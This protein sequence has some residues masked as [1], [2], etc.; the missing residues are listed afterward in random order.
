MTRVFERNGLPGP[1][2]RAFVIGVGAYPTAK[3]G[4]IAPDGSTP[5]QLQNVPD[6]S[7]AATG[8]ALFADWLIRSADTL[9]AT[10]A[11][12]DL[13]LNVQTD[14]GLLSAYSWTDRLP[15]PTGATDPRGGDIAV[16]SPDTDT[17]RD[18][19]KVWRD[20]LARGA[21]NIAILYICGHGAMLGADN[22]V[23]LSDLNADNGAPWNALL[24]I[25]THA[26]AF[27]TIP[28][29]ASAFFFVD[30]CSEY[31][32]AIRKENPGIGAQFATA[33]GRLG[34]E[35][36]TVLSAASDEYLTYEGSLPNQPDVKV[37][38]FTQM[39]LQGLGGAAVRPGSA[40]GTWAIN[41]ISLF[42]SLKPLYKVRLDWERDQLPF[43]PNPPVLPADRF[44]I[45]SWGVPPAVPLAVRFRPPRTEQWA[46]ELRDHQNAIVD[47]RPLGP[48]FEWSI[49]PPAS[50]YPYT[51][52]GASAAEKKQMP[53]TTLQSTFCYEL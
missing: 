18:T 8:A 38:R 33:G 37:G 13:L 15:V 42:E 32:D 22:V 3:P 31:I 35:K 5:F 4:N 14:A 24:N 9:G 27:K 25:Q 49:A 16:G 34:T 36:V 50:L 41:G 17:V 30:A 44:E 12:V 19:G 48:P 6:I 10:L 11:S 40:V 21:G 53:V 51:L 52:Q 29:L 7:S 26:S 45:V 43:T 1:V 28:L 47:A 39:L 23:L 2:A 20:E 46:L